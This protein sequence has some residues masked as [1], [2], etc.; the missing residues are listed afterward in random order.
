MQLSIDPGPETTTEPDTLN[1]CCPHGKEHWLLQE[2]R[3]GFLDA[4]KLYTAYDPGPERWSLDLS[5]TMLAAVAAL[6]DMT[7]IK[8]LHQEQLEP[9][10]AKPR[11][12]QPCIC[13]GIIEAPV[14]RNTAVPPMDP[15]LCSNIHACIR[16]HQ[17]TI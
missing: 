3:P 13:S 1:R 14:S 4:G 17:A 10:P 16:T 7:G 9:Q 8:A 2:R 6:L 5:S 11:H 12:T 15:R